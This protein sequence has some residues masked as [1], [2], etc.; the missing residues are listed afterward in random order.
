M[1]IIEA[2]TRAREDGFAIGAFNASDLA[3]IKGIVQAAKALSSPVIIEASPS[4]ADFIGINNLASIVEN[5][6]RLFELPIFI[7][8][9][10]SVS[11]SSV[12]EGLK[13]GFDIVHFDG[14]SFEIEE[15]IAKTE[16]VVAWAH[17]QGTLVEAEMDKIT[18]ESRQHHQTAESYQAAG[19]YTDPKIAAMF[20]AKSGCD[21]LAT[22]VGNVHGIYKGPIRLDLNR[23]EMIRKNVDCFLSLHGG[24]GIEEEDVKK[25]IKLGRVVKINVSTEIRVAYCASLEKSLSGSEEVAPYKIFVPVVEAVQKV[26]EEKIKLFGSEG[27]AN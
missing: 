7:N 20:A 14:S 19:N 8:L 18:G 11:L 26:V 2:F 16:D 22:F 9:D 17:T 24:S 6:R 15:N 23:L 21:V 25:A 27:K 13:C 10:H 4:E 1:N 3:T 5:Y 12:E